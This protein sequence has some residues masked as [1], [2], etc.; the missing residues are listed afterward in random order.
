MEVVKESKKRVTKDP[1]SPDT[2]SKYFVPKEEDTQQIFPRI[3]CKNDKICMLWLGESTKRPQRCTKH[4]RED[5]KEL[6]HPKSSAT[7]GNVKTKILAKGYRYLSSRKKL[8][9]RKQCLQDRS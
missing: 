1:M 7:L 5:Q 4:L 6:D 3:I 2:Q 9:S 8:L